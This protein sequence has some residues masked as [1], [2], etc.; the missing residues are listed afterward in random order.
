MSKLIEIQNLKKHYN[1]GKLKALDGIDVSIEKGKIYGLIGPNGAGKTTF[2]KLILGASFPTCGNITINNYPAGSVE[3]YKLIGYVCEKNALPLTETL[4]EYLFDAASLSGIK[5]E[6]IPHIIDNKLA[7]F[8]LAEFKLAKLKSFSS[9]MKKK[10]QIIAALLTKPEILIL[11]EPTANLDPVIR[12]EIIDYI[13]ELSDKDD[14]TIIICSHNLD[15]LEKIID[16]VIMINKGKLIVEG[17]YPELIQIIN[18]KQRF[19]LETKNNE[20][21]IDYFK[22]LSFVEFISLKPIII[23]TTD[24]DKFQE[25]MFEFMYKNRVMIKEL[26][27]IKKSLF[28]IF[29]YFNKREVD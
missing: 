10:A 1:N 9:G 17:S 19:S 14:V 24:V 2:V 15:E 22:K 12:F 6:N 27:V 3:A 11:D 4:Y 18:E 8:K 29:E 5:R 7:E 26:N 13:K 16:N 25:E 28:E 21:F 23:E 20:L